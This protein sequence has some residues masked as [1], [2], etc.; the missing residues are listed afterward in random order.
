MDDE[1]N[2]L[3]ISSLVDEIK[4]EQGEA[5]VNKNRGFSSNL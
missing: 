2:L 4:P 1:L 5:M 3:P